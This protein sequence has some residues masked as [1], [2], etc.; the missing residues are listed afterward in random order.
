MSSVTQL[1][2]IGISVSNIEEWEHFGTEV[3]GLQS[4]GVDANGVLTMRMDEYTHRFI[5]SPGEKDDVEFVGFQVTDEAALREMA[6]Q[7]RDAGIEVSQ[8]TPDE[9]RA[10][11]YTHLTLPT[12]RIV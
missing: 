8:G 6:E 7:L 9:A 10:V 11:S 2:Y 5:V 12:K 3:L 4:N 1:G